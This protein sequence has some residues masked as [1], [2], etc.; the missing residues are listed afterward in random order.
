MTSY[1]LVISE[2]ER[3]IISAVV[4]AFQERVPNSVLEWT[5]Q[6]DD[7]RNNAFIVVTASV[8]PPMKN[9]T[10]PESMFQHVRNA[11]NGVHGV[12]INYCPHSRTF[13]YV[14]DI[15]RPGIEVD[16]SQPFD[17]IPSFRPFPYTTDRRRRFDNEHGLKLHNKG[18]LSLARTVA[19][20]WEG[21]CSSL[22]GGVDP[23]RCS[24]PTIDITK[25]KKET[26]QATAM[27]QGGVSVS[28]P[29]SWGTHSVAEIH[30]ASGLIRRVDLH[31]NLRDDDVLVSVRVVIDTP[32]GRR[33]A[34]WV[35]AGKGIRDIQINPNRVREASVFAQSSARAEKKKD[36]RPIF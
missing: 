31:L 36:R 8:P 17:V 28:V 20:M 16:D 1:P 22:L 4:T 5:P 34:D 2:D 10:F 33:P 21:G 27:V 11:D 19:A 24:V 6:I 9:V 35:Q 25:F 18:Q 26:A 14:V 15:A 13:L 29:I 30:K 7:G 23:E 12:Y 32:D 3:K